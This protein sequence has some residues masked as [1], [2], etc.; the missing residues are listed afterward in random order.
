VNISHRRC[1]R[2]V[3]RR[4]VEN[5]YQLQQSGIVFALAKI[6]P[7]LGLKTKIKINFM[8]LILKDKFKI[9]N[10]EFAFNIN[11]L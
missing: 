11:N 5:D 6:V 7:S 4:A 2:F 10:L 9:K 8:W 3:P 1:S